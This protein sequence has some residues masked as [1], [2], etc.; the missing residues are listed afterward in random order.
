M[1]ETI[2]GI[3]SRQLGVEISEIDEDTRIMDDLGA[4][5]LDVVEMVMSIEEECGVAIPDDVVPTLETV[6]DVVNYVENQR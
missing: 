2:K 1:L 5:S 4:D 6:G 3:I